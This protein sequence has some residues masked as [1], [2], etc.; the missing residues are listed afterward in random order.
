[1]F[2]ELTIV[3]SHIGVPWT[4]EMIMVA[5]YPNVYIDT[6]MWA[7]KY[8]PPELIHFMNTY[9]QDKVMFGGTTF[10]LP[11]ERMKKELEELNL[12]PEVRKKFYRENAKKVFKI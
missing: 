5:R 4:S 10:L 1:M 8:Y 12:K 7:P 11:P 9:G 2:P 3:A 6:A